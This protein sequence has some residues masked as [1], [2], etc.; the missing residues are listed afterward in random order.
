MLRVLHHICSALPCIVY[1][2][3]P[4]LSMRCK[5]V[6]VAWAVLHPLTTTTAAAVRVG[7]ASTITKDYTTRFRLL[8]FSL[9]NNH[10]LCKQLL[11]ANLQPDQFVR[12]TKEQLA[13]SRN[14]KLRQEVLEK[15]RRRVVL[16]DEAAAMF[17]TAANLAMANK[18]L[19]V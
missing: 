19:Q 10:D 6:L 9:K 18:E 15:S 1:I 5:L 11:M 17:S 3:V 13:D 4:A 16:D 2:L 8:F 12:L 7:K 14:L